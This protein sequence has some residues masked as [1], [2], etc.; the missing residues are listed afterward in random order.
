MCNTGKNK[1]RRK[2]NNTN[3]QYKNKC[4]RNVDDILICRKKCQ[5]CIFCLFALTKLNAVS[6]TTLIQKNS[7]DI[8][9]GY[10]PSLSTSIYSRY[11]YDLWIINEGLGGNIKKCGL[12]IKPLS[13]PLRIT[14]NTILKIMFIIFDNFP[15]YIREI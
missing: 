5:E 6:L 8:D 15:L 11:I 12:V 1:W 9:L 10:R 3:N 7:N 14:I 4:H 2:V 13:F